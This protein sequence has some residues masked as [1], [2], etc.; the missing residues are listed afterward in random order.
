[1]TDASNC[2]ACNFVCPQ[3]STCGGGRCSPAQ[4]ANSTAAVIACSSQ[5]VYFADQGAGLYQVP[6][7]GGAPC[8]CAPNLGTTSYIGANNGYVAWIAQ[9]SGSTHY[10]VEVVSEL[11]CCTKTPTQVGTAVTPPPFIDL[12]LGGGVTTDGV[13]VYWLDGTHVYQ[14]P[15]TGGSPFLLASLAFAGTGL[16]VADPYV[17]VTESAAAVVTIAMVG[18][19]AGLP[20]APSYGRG[21]Q[22]NADHAV[23]DDDTHGQIWVYTTATSSYGAIPGPQSVPYA[24]GL[25]LDDAFI[26]AGYRT[27]AGTALLSRW[28]LDAGLAAKPTTLEASPVQADYSQLCGS[29]DFLYWI[30]LTSGSAKGQIMKGDKRP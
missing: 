23:W 27:D 15:I 16:A 12:T 9:P 8:A 13:N 17:Y 7:A 20:S 1:M 5:Y 19:D 10:D 21:V 3:G 6:L 26:Y 30:T 4:F 18:K 11:D 2:G 28:A 25:A 29:G 22:A 24:T 14:A